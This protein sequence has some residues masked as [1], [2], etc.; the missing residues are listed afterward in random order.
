M[1][2]L[3]VAVAVVCFPLAMMAQ[4]THFKT[5]Q[6]GAFASISL[7]PD[8]LTTISMNVSRGTTNGA[9]S[10]SIAFFENAFASDFNSVTITEIFGN[11]PNTAFTGDN[12]QE[13]HLSLA[14][15][16]LDPTSSFS[17][18][19]VLDLITFT[20]TCSPI[21]PGSITLSFRTNGLASTQILTCAT[22]Q[23]FG[24]ITVRSHQKG[25][26]TSANV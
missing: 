6:E 3:L 25:T 14:T 1:K 4:N 22:V 5:N 18:S 17:E 19:C 26:T 7:S 11:I 10:T 20:L 12:V 23:T 15:T 16:A 21:T 9:T 13:L 24:P 2:K 8:P